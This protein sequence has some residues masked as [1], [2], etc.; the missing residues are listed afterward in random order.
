[1]RMG[2]RDFSQKSI[3]KSQEQSQEQKKNEEVK[4]KVDKKKK[5]EGQTRY[6]CVYRDLRDEKDIPCN[7]FQEFAWIDGIEFNTKIQGE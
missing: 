1:M 3:L 5:R 4:E 7:F 6:R 2:L